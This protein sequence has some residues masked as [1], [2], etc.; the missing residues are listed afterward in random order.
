MSDI[1][2]R[3]PSTPPLPV[4]CLAFQSYSPLSKESGLRVILAYDFM[5][6][7]LKD[8]LLAH[9]MNSILTIAFPPQEE[10]DEE[11]E[12]EEEGEMGTKKVLKRGIDSEAERG[13]EKVKKGKGEKRDKKD[14]ENN[15][16]ANERK[17]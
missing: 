8:C 3:Y 4:D 13:M 2:D 15:S 7:T 1:S 16:Y 12:K 11:E 5:R 17:R 10:R 14:S 9:A 6:V